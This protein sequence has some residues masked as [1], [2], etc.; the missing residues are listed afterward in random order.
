MSSSEFTLCGEILG[1]T[2]I[3]VWLITWG[4]RRIRYNKDANDK[5]IK[6]WLEKEENKNYLKSVLGG[7]L[8]SDSPIPTEI[9]DFI[10]RMIKM[11]VGSSFLSGIV[12]PDD[13]QYLEPSVKWGFLS[14]ETY[15]DIGTI[16]TITD[17]GKKLV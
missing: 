10:I 2:A 16:Y 17:K 6:G 7:N 11:N 9:T 13:L 15:K 1:Y 3:T 12:S 5:Q 4:I 8:T 14:K